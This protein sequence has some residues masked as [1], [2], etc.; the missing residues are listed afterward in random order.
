KRNPTASE[1]YYHCAA[2]CYEAGLDEKGLT[3]L[4]NALLIDYHNHYMLFHH[5][6]GLRQDPDVMELIEQYR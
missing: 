5:A 4:E 3:Y 6:P 1:L 2:Y